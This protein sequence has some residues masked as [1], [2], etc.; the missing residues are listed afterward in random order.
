MEVLTSLTTVT[1]AL[2]AD[3]IKDAG[4]VAVNCVALLN[5]LLSA[6]PT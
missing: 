3:A 5:T 6:V 1:A 2:P 4:T